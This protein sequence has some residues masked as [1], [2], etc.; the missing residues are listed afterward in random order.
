ME[1]SERERPDLTV[2]IPSYNSAEW[3]PSTLEAC[4]RALAA[5]SWT[6]EVLVVDDGSTDGT[7]ELITSLATTYPAALRV[8]RQENKGRFLARWAG[9][10]EARA[11]QVLLL[12]SRVLL[13][14]GSL[15]HVEAVTAANPRTTVWNGHCVTDPDAPLVGHFWEVLTHVFWGGYL[16]A[17]EPVEFGLETFNQHPKGTGVFIAPRALLVEACRV[18]WPTGDAALAS[19]DTKLIRHIAAE[20]PIR[21]DPGFVAVYR[22]RGNVRDFVRHSF[23]RG[24]F[25]VDSYAGT[26]AGWNAALVGLAAAPVI[27]LAVLAALVGAQAWTVLGGLAVA[28]VLALAAPAALAARKRCPAK[29]LRA[30]LTYAPVFAVPYWAG[31]LRGL[32]VHGHLLRSTTRNLPVRTEVAA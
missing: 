9:L 2:V 1:Q 12:D 24:T 7:A 13:G 8:L 29:G 32:A 5:T 15:A 6:A 26:S 19:D 17:P 21:L 25:L 31:L 30:Y 3:L 27:G 28:A 23:G 20:V 22:P 10:Q 14:P 18:A 11:E 16:G 4:A